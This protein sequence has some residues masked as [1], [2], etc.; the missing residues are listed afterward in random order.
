M[1][2]CYFHPTFCLVFFCFL[3]VLK[4]IS[5]LFDY[6]LGGSV[7]HFQV[8]FTVVPFLRTVN[9]LLREEKH[10]Q[11]YHV[12]VHLTCFYFIICIWNE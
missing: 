5:V 11:T 4:F 2:F 6:M 7:F 1:Y 8:S 10:I 12:N 9:V 3:L